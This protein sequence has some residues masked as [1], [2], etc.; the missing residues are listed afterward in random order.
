MH[1]NVG[2]AKHNLSSWKKK[3]LLGEK[4]QFY[5]CNKLSEYNFDQ[6]ATITNAWA[7]STHH[8]TVNTPRSFEKCMCATTLIRAPNCRYIRGNVSNLHLLVSGLY[9]N[10]RTCPTSLLPCIMNSSFLVLLL[11]IPPSECIGIYDRRSLH[12]PIFHHSTLLKCSFQRVLL[13]PRNKN[14]DLAK[15]KYLF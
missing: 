5:K 15:A 4:V 3:T 8:H 1:L 10:L 7:R 2:A 11:E 6:L 12:C 13:L 9:E 14:N